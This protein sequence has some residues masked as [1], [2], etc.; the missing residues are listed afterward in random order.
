MNK[1]TL[2]GG[3]AGLSGKPGGRVGR[4][5][6]RLPEDW[7]V[8]VAARGPRAGFWVRGG[9]RIEEAYTRAACGYQTKA[10]ASGWCARKVCQLYQVPHCAQHS[11]FTGYSFNADVPFRRCREVGKMPFSWA[12]LGPCPGFSGGH[13]DSTRHICSRLRSDAWERHGRHQPGSGA[14]LPRL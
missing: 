4:A 6:Q 12:S 1:S 3:F 14:R 2:L 11:G 13:H 8:H 9:R 7:A 10:C 5:E